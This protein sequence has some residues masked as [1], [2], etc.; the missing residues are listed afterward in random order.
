MECDEILDL[1]KREMSDDIT[2]VIGFRDKT[3]IF[4][5]KLKNGKW[6]ESRIYIDKTYYDPIVCEDGSEY[7]VTTC[8][9][10]LIKAPNVSYYRINESV[11]DISLHA[12]KNCPALLKLDIPYTVSN[13]YN[14]DDAL[15]YCHH[16]VDSKIWNWPYELERSEELQKNIEDGWT[17]KH[18]FVYSRDKKILLKAPSSNVGKYWIPEG[19]EQIEPYAF[20]GCVFEELNIPYTCNMLN[21]SYDS[22]PIFGSEI[23]QGCVINWD[24]PY[25][26]EDEVD[27]CLCI[28]DGYFCDEYGVNYSN[29]MKRLLCANQ[30]FDRNYYYVPDGVIT[31]CSFAFNACKKFLTLSLPA[32]IKVIGCSLFGE[33]GGRII[34]RK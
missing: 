32:S 34:I 21:L 30:L 6:V 7:I 8:G 33:N 17:D 9:N 25:S 12:F 15:S 3:T 28:R 11:C 31:I 18:G 4:I 27:N 10:K 2:E 23:V 14:V 26:L 20:I 22:S 1:I 5:E 13:Y 24:K 29:N 16:E 19:V